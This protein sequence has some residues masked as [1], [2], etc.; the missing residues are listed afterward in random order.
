MSTDLPLASSR[1]ALFG[2]A[3]YQPYIESNPRPLKSDAQVSSFALLINITLVSESPFDYSTIYCP[4]QT[5]DT[6]MLNISHTFARNYLN[7]YQR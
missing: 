7:H 6:D 2:C 5:Y 4:Q 1:G 3:R